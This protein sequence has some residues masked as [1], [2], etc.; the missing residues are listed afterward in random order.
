MSVCGLFPQPSYKILEA[1]GMPHMA[2]SILLHLRLG[3]PEAELRLGFIEK[4]RR[5]K[6]AREGRGGS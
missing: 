3:S 5:E 6:E 4:K 1:E 2:S